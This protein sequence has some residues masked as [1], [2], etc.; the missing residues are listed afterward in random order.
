MKEVGHKLHT[1]IQE[2]QMNQEPITVQWLPDQQ[3]LAGGLTTSLPTQSAD[4]STWA[5]IISNSW[6][7]PKV[8]GGR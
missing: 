2:M 1:T 6:G 3:A 7:Q 8:N 4:I 5:V